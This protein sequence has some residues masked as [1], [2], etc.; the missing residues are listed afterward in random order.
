MWRGSTRIFR[1]ARIVH[2]RVPYYFPINLWLIVWWME[3]N[4]LIFGT[5]KLRREGIAENNHNPTFFWWVILFFPAAWGHSDLHKEEYQPWCDYIA[6]RGAMNYS[7]VGIQTPAF[8]V[9]LWSRPQILR[10]RQQP[11]GTRATPTTVQLEDMKTTPRRLAEAT[12]STVSVYKSGWDCRQQIEI[13]HQLNVLSPIS[14]RRCRC[15]D[16][17]GPEFSLF[18]ACRISAK[19]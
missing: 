1:E 7:L 16:P 8:K 19:I 4:A 13:K 12:A 10:T 15:R 18:W 3:S 14:L 9:H 2:H 11:S 5:A 6:W 17:V